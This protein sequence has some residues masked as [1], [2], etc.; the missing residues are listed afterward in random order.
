MS[1]WFGRS[2]PFCAGNLACLGGT[3]ASS[4]P[5]CWVFVGLQYGVMLPG[6]FYCLYRMTRE[7]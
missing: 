5:A 2:L 1:K 6:Q 7:W 4:S 3:L